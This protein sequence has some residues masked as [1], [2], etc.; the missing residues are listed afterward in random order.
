MTGSIIRVDDV[1]REG[2]YQPIDVGK[3][4]RLKGAVSLIP[5]NPLPESPPLEI[6]DL[7]SRLLRPAGD[8][9]PSSSTGSRP[10]AGSRPAVR[11]CLIAARRR[12]IVFP[13]CTPRSGRI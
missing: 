8:R 13:L 1:L 3:D 5:A 2:G 12:R 7:K 11:C 9:P 6:S 4:T 10:G